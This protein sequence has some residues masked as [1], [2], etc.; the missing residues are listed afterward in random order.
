M[1]RVARPLV[2]ALSS[3][4]LL[5]RPASAVTSAVKPAAQPSYA[6]YYGAAPIPV[7]EL[8]AFD[9]VVVEP[10]SGFDPSQVDTPHTDW[11]AYASVGEVTPQRD[12]FSAIPKAWL[13][14]DNSAWG[15][16]VVDQ[17]APGWPAFFVE[18]VIDPL[19]QRGFRGF[20]FDTLD[21]FQLIAKTDAERQRQIAGLVR[22]IDAV[23]TRYPQ[24]R[25]V[26][27]RGF[28]ILP[29]VH[30]WV[31]AVAFES[32][33]KGW[34]Q[35]K[36]LFTEV[37]PSD[38]DWLMAQVQPLRDS[39][40][41][42][43]IAIDYCPDTDRQCALETARRISAQGLIPYVSD[44][45]LQRVG[46]G[47]PQ[48]IP[49]RILMLQDS[50]NRVSLNVSD[51][52]R[53][54]ATPLNYLGLR[55]DY[56]NVN[57]DPLPEGPL[58]DRYAGVVL[59]LNDRVDQP[60]Q[61][62][63]WV[64]RQIAAG[65][66][67]V[68]IGTFGMPVAGPFAQALGLQPAAGE[69]DGPLRVTHAD[70]TLMG[71]EVPPTP[72]PRD[73]TPVRLGAQGRS[74]LRLQSGD[75]EFDAAALMPWG[76]YV[77]R[78]FAVLAMDDMSQ[79]RWVLQPFEFLRQALNLRDMPVPDP[80]T[81]NG[82]RLFMSHIDG[83]GFASKVEFQDAGGATYSGEALYR[84]LKQYGLPVTASVIEGEVS[85]QGPNAAI[86][87][88]L[89][90]IARQIFALPN[91]EMASHTYTHPLPWMQVTGE[92]VATNDYDRAE[93]TGVQSTNGL[94]INV[95]G[96]RFNLE[97]EIGG[98]V[99]GIN[100]LM[101]PAGKQVKVLLW[102]GDCQVPA[103]ALKQAYQAG[104]LNMNGGD[105]LITRSNPS[106]TDVAP[107][108][109]MKDGYYQVFAPNQNEE[110]YTALWQG[111]YYGFRRVLETFELTEHPRRIK[112]IDVYYHMFTGTK[113]ASLTALNTVLQSV[114]RQPI[115]PV[116]V[117]DYARKVL[118]TQQ[119][120]VARDGDFWVIRNAGWLRTVRVAPDLAPDLSDARGVA[121]FLPGPDGVYVHMTGSEAR[122][123]LIPLGRAAAQNLPWLA[124]ANGRIDAFQRT[125]ERLSFELTSYVAPRFTIAGASACR[126]RVA[127]KVIAGE[128]TPEGRLFSLGPIG[129]PVSVNQQ[130]VHVDVDCRA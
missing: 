41:L 1:S 89:R 10:D 110:I 43:V 115:H 14:G 37:P 94:A 28:E 107:Q 35:G 78:P 18:H 73:Y 99:A 45:G 27:N 53:Y 80:T 109:V 44:P 32:L 117:S 19:W 49:T 123:R 31:D 55:L 29:Q 83:D 105:T 75:L 92:G 67:V 102:S 118:D 39:Y 128:K 51:G 33:Y 93:G 3:A 23:K 69:V 61:L 17:S 90:E 113:E 24:A 112:P 38:R 16:Q 122:F 108:G 12:F 81:E 127:G 47:E 64:L 56:L 40:K 79:A 30:Q 9:H 82:L 70:A 121:G 6:F 20:F 98:S 119:T 95:P 5:A 66:R 91:V 77:M 71:Y 58:A 72:D 104:V 84:V 103:V 76:G 87:P 13:K 88:R 74:L 54:L 34:D 97:R 11:L 100:R 124:S 101:A 68:F 22:V 96:Y 106:L 63:Q 86:A 48:P 7:A 125:P 62:R 42:P 46:I 57:Q 25:L 2:L 129:V 111:P 26:F 59:W 85:D 4:L 65:V 36:Q 15:S 130:S 116:F 21:S 50:P 114:T 52:V 60:E 120:S 8:S 126:V